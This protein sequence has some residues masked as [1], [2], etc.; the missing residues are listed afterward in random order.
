[1]EKLK[2]IIFA[3]INTILIAFDIL[4]DYLYV[5]SMDFSIPYLNIGA[6]VFVILFP[7]IIYIS[8]FILISKETKNE[9]HKKKYSI[10]WAIFGV[11]L[12]PL[13]P[14]FFSFYKC[15]TKDKH[16]LLIKLSVLEFFFESL[17]QLIIQSYNNYVTSNY[18]SLSK[19]SIA[20]SI[21]STLKGSYILSK[22]ITDYGKTA[23]RPEFD[24]THFFSAFVGCLIIVDVLSMTLFWIVNFVY[25]LKISYGGSYFCAAIFILGNFFLLVGR[26]RSIHKLGNFILFKLCLVSHFQDCTKLVLKHDYEFIRPWLNDVLFLFMCIFPLTWLEIVYIYDVE[27]IKFPPPVIINFLC[28]LIT[29]FRMCHNK[30]RGKNSG[31]QVGNYYS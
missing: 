15:F 13:Y 12:S 7:I 30:I 22:M 18:T 29:L 3:A 14:M 6:V 28:I 10:L 11:I 17:P 27:I 8:G 1:M 9:S 24:C 16:R 23:K 2:S 5:V 25:I 19:A 4:S 31:Y 21:I 20:F 26:H